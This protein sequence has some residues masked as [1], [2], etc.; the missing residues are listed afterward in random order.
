MNP[1]SLYYT[2]YRN[3]ILVDSL[4]QSH[5]AQRKVMVVES[6]YAQQLNALQ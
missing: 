4:Q 3:A 2:D 1:V 6:E 5:E